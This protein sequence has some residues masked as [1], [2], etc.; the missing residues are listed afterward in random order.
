MKQKVWGFCF[1]AVFLGMESG[2]VSTK[3]TG[4]IVT[5]V[6]VS[7]GRTSAK[8]EKSELQYAEIES[9][10]RTT[11]TDDNAI[12]KIDLTLSNGS[13]SVEE[14]GYKAALQQALEG[15]NAFKKK[16]SKV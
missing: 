12:C 3:N 7:N 8:R 9:M 2:C 4:T 13:I 14:K 1:L 6:E 5:A 10:A 16:L 11:C 15:I